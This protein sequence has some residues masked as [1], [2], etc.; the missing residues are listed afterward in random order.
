[1][2]HCSAQTSSL[3]HKSMKDEKMCGDINRLRYWYKLG[4]VHI[5]MFSI[6]YFT[7]CH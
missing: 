1:M 4:L 7:A 5:F 2:T 6:L 3:T